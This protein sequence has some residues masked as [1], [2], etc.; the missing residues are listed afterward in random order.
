LSLIAK[1]DLSRRVIAEI[2]IEGGLRLVDPTGSEAARIGTT[3]AISTDRHEL[4]RPWSLVTY[5]HLSSPDGIHYR[6]KHDLS[7]KGVA[8]FDREG[9]AD[10]VRAEARESS[11]TRATRA[12]RPDSRRVRLRT[13]TGLLWSRLRL[14][15]LVGWIETLT[16]MADLLFHLGL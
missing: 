11:W 10:A 6:L 7:R 9:M 13:G 15:G 3:G 16:Q 4:V 12:S 1:T 2:A 5:E 14:V 8:I